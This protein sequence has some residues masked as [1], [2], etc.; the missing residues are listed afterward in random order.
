MDVET[1]QHHFEASHVKFGSM[2]VD[3]N[4]LTYI[5]YIKWRYVMSCQTNLTCTKLV[6]LFK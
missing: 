6:G 5:F 1:T 4:E 3:I 2:D